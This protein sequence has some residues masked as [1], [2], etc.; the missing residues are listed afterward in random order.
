M[1]EQYTYLTRTVTLAEAGRGSVFPNPMVGALLVKEGEV[2]ATGYH[3]RYGEA[4]AEAA[5]LDVAGESAEGSTLYCN[6]EPCSYE[7]PE[8]HQPPCTR[9]IIESGVRTVVIG[10]LD[11]NPRI[12]G[13]GVRILEEAGIEVRTAED[14]ER[15]WRFNDAFNTYMSAGRP[16]VQIKLAMS[17]DGRIATSRGE[18]KWITDEAARSEVHALRAERDAVAVGVGT[19]IADNPSLTVRLV[20]GKNPRPV[21]FDTHLRIPLDRTLLRERSEELIVLAGKPPAEDPAFNV[22]KGRLEALGVTVRVV[23]TERGWVSPAEALR[24]LAAAGVRSLLLEGGA[25]LATSF[26]RARLFDR[27]TAY[28]APFLIG[29]GREAVGQLG[30]DEMG[31]ALRLEGVTWRRIGEQQRF[32][33]YRPGWLDA[34]QASVREESHVHGAR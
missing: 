33:G 16:F 15:Y 14:S 24:A 1:S 26:L 6:L 8:K 27:L 31:Q 32:D 28:I 7:S 10:Q 12:R 11:P 19:V 22:R 17:L 20:E 2:I 21:V 30:V 34:T 29:S 5:A 9:R 18:S 3:G 23:P 25:T 13:R 4:H